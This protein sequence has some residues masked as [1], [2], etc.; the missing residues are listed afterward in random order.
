MIL[1][2]AWENCP[3]DVDALLDE[4]SAGPTQQVRNRGLTTALPPDSRLE[5]VTTTGD[6]VLVDLKT[7]TQIS[8]DRL[9]TAIG[10]VVLTLASAPGITRVSLLSDGEP[11]QIPD[12]DG[13]AGVRVS[14]SNH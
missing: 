9:P 13:S 14:T 12:A 2:S 5:L 4:L 8:A 6:L 10:Q 1:R 3:L 11:V 7:E